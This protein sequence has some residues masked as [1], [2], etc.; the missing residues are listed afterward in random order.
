LLIQSWFK[1]IWDLADGDADGTL[2]A[3]E[4]AVA[5]YF[6]DRAAEGR[7]DFLDAT[8]MTLD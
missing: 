4:F 5:S 2:T 1:V 3:P 6:L 7:Y 8:S